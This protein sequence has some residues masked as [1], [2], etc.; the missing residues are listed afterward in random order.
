MCREVAAPVRDARISSVATVSCDSEPRERRRKRG[1][2]SRAA[3]AA[4]AGDARRHREKM[5]VQGDLS[6]FLR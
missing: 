6:Q 1:E 2:I 3:A 5:K 4:A